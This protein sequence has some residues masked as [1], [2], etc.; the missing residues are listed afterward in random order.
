MAD[1]TFLHQPQTPWTGTETDGFSIDV[2]LSVEAQLR[3]LYLAPALSAWKPNSQLLQGMSPEEALKLHS[4]RRGT[5]A[6]R[7]WA[8]LAAGMEQQSQW[9]LAGTRLIV[10]IF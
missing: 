2:V 5:G 8:Q 6:Q 9:S 10:E 4:Y 1:D 3:A 7:P